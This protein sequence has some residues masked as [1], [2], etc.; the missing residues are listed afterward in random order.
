[1]IFKKEEIIKLFDIG[2][3]SYYD[4]FKKLKITANKRLY[5]EL[6]E[7]IYDNNIIVNFDKT[8]IV[9][10]RRIKKICI[11]CNKTYYGISSLMETRKYCSVKCSNKNKIRGAALQCSLHPKRYKTI[12]FKY[13]KKKCIVCGEINEIDVHHFD[14]NKKNNSPNNLIPVCPT[15]HRYLHGK[16][17]HLIIDNVISY[18]KDFEKTFYPQK[19]EDWNQVLVT[20]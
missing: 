10:K 15:H 4:L 17:K 11:A 1:M 12:C 9:R 16:F 8:I 5:N 18:K 13:H 7:F 2:V 20:D 3:S 14:G 19:D 6:K